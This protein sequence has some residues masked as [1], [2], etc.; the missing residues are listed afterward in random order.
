MP[1]AMTTASGSDRALGIVVM[2][3]VVAEIDQSTIAHIFGDKAVE[4]GHNLCNGTVIGSDDLAQILG[5]QS[6]RESGRADEVTEHHG[7]LPSLRT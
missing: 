6:R 4:P 1:A 2:C 3:P 7:E 5:T